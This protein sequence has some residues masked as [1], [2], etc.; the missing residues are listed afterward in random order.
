MNTKVITGIVTIAIVCVG[1]STNRTA[2]SATPPSSTAPAPA[3]PPPAP[4]PPKTL[5]LPAGT[6][7]PV[8]LG[9]TLTTKENHTGDAFTATLDKALVVDG[10]TVAQKG[11]RVEGH[12][13]NAEEA[14]RVK[15][16]A[17]L[18]IALTRLHTADGK[19]V[20]IHTAP[21]E[22]L[23]PESKA[24]D[25]E[26]IGIGAAAGAIIGAIAGGGKGAAIGA[27]AG[28]AAGTGVVLGTRGKP[29]EL[30]VETRVSFRLT[31]SVTLTQTP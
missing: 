6:L 21:F 3:S 10:E 24:E 12:I 18:S 16:V 17:K 5:T 20:S 15:G 13:V 8:R 11:A 9:E 4:E 31:N 29:A 2:D 22:K 23:G 7:V 19:S 27:G 14:G 26:K 28:G 30:P 25:A 1:C